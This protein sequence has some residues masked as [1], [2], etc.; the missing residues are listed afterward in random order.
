MKVYIIGPCSLENYDLSYNVLNE[1][2]PYLK[3]RPRAK[4]ALDT[5][6][7]NIGVLPP[8]KYKIK[9]SKFSKFDN[10]CNIYKHPYDNIIFLKYFHY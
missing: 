6:L 10:P 8:N 7:F 9:F 5:H 1:I 3:D 2:Y 4:I